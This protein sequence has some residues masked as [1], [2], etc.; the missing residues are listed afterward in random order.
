MNQRVLII[1]ATSAIA[2][3]CARLWAAD[4]ASFVLVGRRGEALEQNASDLLARGA[5]AVSTQVHDFADTAAGDAWL[6]DAWD[7][8]GQVDIVLVAYG[9]LPDQARCEA[10][11]LAAMQA[12]NANGSSVIDLLTRVANRMQP[13]RQGVIAVISSVAGDRGRA[14][15]YVYGAAK[16]AVSTF[17]SGLRARLVHA[18]I[19][20]VTIKP[21]FVATPM[22]AGLPLP[23]KLVVSAEVAGQGIVKAIAARRN[24][25]YVP[26]FWWLI[27]TITRL[28]PEALFKRLKL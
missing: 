3:A 25:A 6:G 10:D 15:N 11:P 8:L 21:G 13:Q 24:V 9:T 26:G 4:Q 19:H 14:S 22:T 5:L 20:V 23:A 1:G 2:H 28:I 27:M 18:G 12:F 16:A 7:R 17:C